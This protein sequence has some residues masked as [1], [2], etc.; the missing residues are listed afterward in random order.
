MLLYSEEVF[1]KN[2]IVLFFIVIISLIAN[3]S[4]IT[5]APATI[6]TLEN[7]PQALVIK[8]NSIPSG[9][10]VFGLVGETPGT[11]LGTTPLT[12]RYIIPT[13]NNWETGTTSGGVPVNAAVY[14]RTMGDIYI[15]GTQPTET[16][17]ISYP[18]GDSSWM[19]NGAKAVIFGCIVVAEGYK[20]YIINV[21]ITYE[22]INSRFDAYPYGFLLTAFRSGQRRNLTAIL[23]SESIKLEIQKSDKGAK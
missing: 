10:S 4:C 6:A 22:R 11:L 12:L 5:I 7:D 2:R 19:L 20:P 8:I 15:Y 13:T 3:I 16:I 1:M 17:S 21:N 23:Q 14:R 18:Q 9:A